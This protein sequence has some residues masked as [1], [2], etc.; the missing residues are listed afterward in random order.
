MLDK[1][2]D[3]LLES[4]QDSDS[5]VGVFGG[6]ETLLFLELCEKSFTQGEVFVGRKGGR[7]GR[8]DAPLASGCHVYSVCCC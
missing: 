4:G 6:F 8:G 2:G 7:D 5:L 3:D 1:L